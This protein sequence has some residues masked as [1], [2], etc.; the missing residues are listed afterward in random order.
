VARDRRPVVITDAPEDPEKELRRREIRYVL[1]ML[2]R[3]GCLVV[4]A[5]LVTLRPPLWPLWVVLCVVG[6]V[7]LPWLAVI[8]AN[9]RPPKTK[10]ERLQ[11]AQRHAQQ[12]AALPTSR[13]RKTIDHE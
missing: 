6:M 10:A 8:L 1:M 4:A 2:T 9:D 13:E 12:P 3:A 7:L 5:V 11:D